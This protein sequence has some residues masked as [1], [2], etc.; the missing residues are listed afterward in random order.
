MPHGIIYRQ[1]LAYY[2]RFYL[3][4]WVNKPLFRVKPASVHLSLRHYE[5]DI[6]RDALRK[7]LKKGRL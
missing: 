1:D 3:V 6:I 2:S 7:I 5:F 4:L